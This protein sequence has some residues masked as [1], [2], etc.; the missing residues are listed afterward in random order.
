VNIPFSK[1][2][3]LTPGRLETAEA[4]AKSL[5]AM[6]E[7]CEVLEFPQVRHDFSDTMIYWRKTSASKP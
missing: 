5:E 6:I 1:L 4:I 3:E 2:A 7:G